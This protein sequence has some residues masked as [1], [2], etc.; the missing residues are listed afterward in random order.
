[1]LFPTQGNFD[2]GTT[3]RAPLSDELKEAQ[4]AVVGTSYDAVR[5]VATPAVQTVTESTVPALVK[6]AIT[7]AP[8]PADALAADAARV[9]AAFQAGS[10]TSSASTDGTVPA[11]SA[12]VAEQF[13]L[14]EAERSSSSG[15]K[16]HSVLEPRLWSLYCQTRRTQWLL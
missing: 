16:A 14:S 8:L 12:T 1:M 4:L 10:S 15:I 13:K 5:P 9:S 11:A 2:K 6:T 3:G 7:A